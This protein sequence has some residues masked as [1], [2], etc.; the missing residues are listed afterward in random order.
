LRFL[1][2][3]L[4][5]WL[6]VFIYFAYPVAKQA[7]R[8]A[9]LT[10]TVEPKS[11]HW[12]VREIHD[13]KWQFQVDYTYEIDGRLFEKQELFQGYSYRNPY[14]AK[15]T[16]QEIIPEYPVVWYSPDK[17]E[18]SSMEKFFPKKQATYSVIVFMLFV[19]F[20]GGANLILKKINRGKN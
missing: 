1:I 12:Q 9:P 11:A 7:Y 19:Y 10:A 14:A 6:A 13:E 3:F 15:E 16:L 2:F 17:P 20:I 4:G 18:N 5:L 8:N